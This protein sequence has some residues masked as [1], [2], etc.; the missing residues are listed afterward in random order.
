M[1]FAI[2][3]DQQGVPYSDY[4]EYHGLQIGVQRSVL[5]VAE[6]GL[7][8]WQRFFQPED[9]GVQ[10]SYD[11]RRHPKNKEADP[12]DPKQALSMLLA[13]AD[14]LRDEVV[15]CNNGEFAVWVYPYPFSYGT[16]PGWRSA[17]AQAVGLQLLARAQEV[18][19]DGHYMSS[20]KGLFMAFSVPVAE[21]GLLERTHH[22]GVWFEKM[23]D[24]N[25]QQPKVLNGM[26]FALLALHDLAERTG[27]AEAAALFEEGVQGV[28]PCLP[29][30]DLGD[31]SAYDVSGRRA[32][33][34]YHAIHINQ[35]NLLYH[36]T[37]IR[38]FA[39][40]CK[41]FE[42]YSKATQKTIT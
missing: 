6:R 38:E 17:H 2:H 29:L 11:W 3:V 34:H 8:Y 42:T 1:A 18:S 28:L 35:L 24:A 22:G 4:G 5:A 26:L 41:K 36:F 40:M 10:L 32:S 16:Q 31:W 9:V 33:A 30:Y 23:A 14:W 39:D 25:N 13:C 7:V 20:A 15:W 19:P 12:Q 27:N 37:H 21:G